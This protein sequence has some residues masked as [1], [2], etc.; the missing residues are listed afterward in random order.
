M[1]G[2][3]QLSENAQHNFCLHNFPFYAMISIAWKKLKPTPS[4]DIFTSKEHV[5]PY[6]VTVNAFP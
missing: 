1:P 6:Q 2:K 3:C 4:P 5:M